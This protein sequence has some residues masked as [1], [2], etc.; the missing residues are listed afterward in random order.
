M[1][2]LVTQVKVR[3]KVWDRVSH[4]RIRT[5]RTNER[6]S[7]AGFSLPSLP[8]RLGGVPRSQWTTAVDVKIFNK[9]LLIHTHLAAQVLPSS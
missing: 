2:E 7:G 8:P 1:H 6:H 9:V 3:I 4:G 5:D